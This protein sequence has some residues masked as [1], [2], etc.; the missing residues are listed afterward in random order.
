MSTV[1]EAIKALNEQTHKKNFHVFMVNMDEVPEG[2]DEEENTA[3]DLMQQTYDWRYAGKI[4]G[5]KLPSDDTVFHVDLTAANMRYIG[6]A[7]EL[8][9]RVHFDM[10]MKPILENMI[11]KMGDIGNEQDE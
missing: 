8:Y 2:T 7:L 11:Q 4:T 10:R 3:H 6:R 9:N 5:H 1:G